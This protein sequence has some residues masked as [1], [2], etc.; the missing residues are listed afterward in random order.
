MGGQAVGVRGA[1]SKRLF[2]G[3]ANSAQLPLGS[4]R[5]L[6]MGRGLDAHACSGCRVGQ[7]AIL[8]QAL[9]LSNARNSPHTPCW[10]TETCT[11]NSWPSCSQGS[12]GDLKHKGFRLLNVSYFMR[13]L[14]NSGGLD[15]NCYSARA[16]SSRVHSLHPHAAERSAKECLTQDVFVGRS[17][18][19]PKEKSCS[20]CPDQTREADIKT[21]LRT[22]TSQIPK[23]T[24][25]TLYFGIL[26]YYF[27]LFGGPGSSKGSS[28]D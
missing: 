28:K 15:P 24:N 25:Y 1:S 5:R 21:Q 18:G 10:P 23:M 2:E 11:S 13:R 22:W 9:R 7:H 20:V 17:K 12:T 14:Y 8:K 27:G 26:G 4:C 16:Y 19:A 6:Y 3:S